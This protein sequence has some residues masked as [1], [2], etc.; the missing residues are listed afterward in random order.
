[1]YLPKGF[2]KKLK[3]ATGIRESNLS[4]YLSGRKRPSFRTLNKIENIKEGIPEISSFSQED[5]LFRPKKIR[6]H[7][8][9][10]KS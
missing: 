2:L 10:F 9:N 4:S 3:K 7:I 6:E 8:L 5:W 1:M